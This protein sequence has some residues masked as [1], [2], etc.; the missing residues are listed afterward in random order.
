MATASRRQVGRGRKIRSLTWA[1]VRRRQLDRHHLLKPESASLIASAVA[2]TCGVQAQILAAA[3][4]AISARVRGITRADVRAALWDRRSLVKLPSL[5]STIHLHSAE[6]VALWVAATRAIAWW[7]TPRWHADAGTSVAQMEAVTAAARDALDGQALTKREL[8]EDVVKRVGK[9]ARAGVKWRPFGQDMSLA[10]WL[11]NPWEGGICFG[12]SR[13]SEVTS[14]RLD[15]WVKGWRELDPRVA[16]REAAR[17]YL[18]THG[19]ARA[20]DFGHWTRMPE[21]DAKRLFESLGDELAEV[22]VEGVR[23]WILADDERFTKGTADL[24]AW[25]DL[26]VRLLPDY[27]CFVIGCAPPGP[28]REQLI[29]EAAGRRVFN[30][31]GGPYAELLLDVVV[32]GLWKRRPKGKRIELRVEPFRRLGAVHR[33]G[34]EV[35]AAR[36]ESFL[37]TPVE[38]K[39]GPIA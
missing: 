11:V 9:W 35:E 34:L 28:A 26:P 24:P 15:Q 36:F 31:G 33:R 2:D 4:L 32:G 14:V 7:R 21:R 19:P 20:V 6:D 27:D 1:D 17:R 37:E 8:E 22:D 5:R 16:L 13:G 25:A 39:V 29:P 18:R 30:R 23:G 10:L 3:E 38:L 12:R